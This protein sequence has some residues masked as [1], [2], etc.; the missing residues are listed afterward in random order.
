MN[1]LYFCQC[2]NCGKAFVATFDR[3]DLVN[4]GFVCPFCD[5]AFYNATEKGLEIEGSVK[6]SEVLFQ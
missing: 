4:D 6:P 1:E 3:L 2:E 5:K